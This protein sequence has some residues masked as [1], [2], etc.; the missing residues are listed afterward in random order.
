MWMKANLC[1]LILVLFNVRWGQA[2]TKAGRTDRPEGWTEWMN[3]LKMM[4]SESLTEC[5]WSTSCCYLLRI[6][7]IVVKICGISIRT[8]SLNSHLFRTTAE[9][10]TRALKRHLA[11]PQTSAFIKC[12][13][14]ICVQHSEQLSN[15]AY[16]Q[17]WYYRPYRYF[18]KMMHGGK[19]KDTYTA[20]VVNGGLL[21]GNRL[22]EHWLG[23]T[24]RMGLIPGVG[25]CPPRKQKLGGL[26][27]LQAVGLRLDAFSVAHR[28]PR[29]PVYFVLFLPTMHQICALDLPTMHHSNHFGD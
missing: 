6:V 27:V 25:S 28:K 3:E 18:S 2:A 16:S 13:D 23:N 14:P 20:E 10:N 26:L 5:E 22:P 29:T 4:I 8:A 11:G 9:S 7:M 12:S 1:C 21:V 24:Y 19:V 15:C 17:D